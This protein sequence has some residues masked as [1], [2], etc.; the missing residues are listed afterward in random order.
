MIAQQWE[1]K[2]YTQAQLLNGN[3]VKKIEIDRLPEGTFTVD[4]IE[5]TYININPPG[6]MDKIKMRN[7]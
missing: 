1:S 3:Y 6:L 7:K 5:W 2:D 4:L